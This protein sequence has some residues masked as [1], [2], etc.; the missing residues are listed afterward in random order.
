MRCRGMCT[1]G[2]VLLQ[3]VSALLLQVEGGGGWWGGVGREVGREVVGAAMETK[4]AHIDNETHRSH[5]HA[6]NSK[7]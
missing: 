5:Q 7:T 2:E 4:S 6:A 1:H 3:R